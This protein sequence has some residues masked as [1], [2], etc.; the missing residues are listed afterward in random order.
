MNA[1]ITDLHR[2]LGNLFSHS[3]RKSEFDGGD[4]FM[5]HSRQVSINVKDGKLSSLRDNLEQGMGM[6][7]FKGSKM[8]FAISAEVN[9]S[10][11]DDLFSNALELIKFIGE[12]DFTKNY[13]LEEIQENY[14][15]KLDI[16]DGYIED[17][18]V[19]PE[20]KYLKGLES[21]C[22]KARREIESSRGASL[23]LFG[24]SFSFCTAGGFFQSFGKSIYSVSLG[25]IAKK[26]S[27]TKSSF[28]HWISIYRNE[29]PRYKAFAR[30]I[31]NKAVRLLGG[32]PINTGK[33]PVLFH[34]DAGIDLFSGI[35]AAFNGDSVIKG[36]S[37]YADSLGKKI[38]NENINLIDDAV[39]VKGV[40][41]IPLD[42]E[43]TRA[44]K[45]YIIRKGVLE[46][47]LTDL[48]SAEKLNLEPTGNAY[49]DSY[50]SRPYISSTNCYLED[51]NSYPIPE[52]I[53]T[54]DYGLY[55]F[56]ILGFGIDPVSG[57][58]SIGVSGLLLED[59][60]MGRPVSRVTI[61]DSFENILNNI[62]MVGNDLVFRGSVSVPHFLVKD[63]TVSGT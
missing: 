63:I 31:A 62:T 17:F 33:Y 16:W 10:G 59:G 22:L 61:A 19:E 39:M 51:N 23:S 54:V 6:R 14:I 40:S 24:G 2:N 25:V 21:D 47:F 11:L 13:R 9:K 15:K 32:E 44:K 49:R 28:D 53:K 57:S 27:E 60:K 7:V 12:S 46:N 34:P 55:V 52:I 43:G 35:I 18:K 5:T 26:G 1:N 50:S 8:V 45:K 30:F 56:E 42:G 58:V 48:N 4:L 29:L 20:I 3:C 38:A 36:S 41:S 37:C